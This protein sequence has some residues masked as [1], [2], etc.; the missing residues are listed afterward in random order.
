MNCINDTIRLETPNGDV[1]ADIN[2]EYIIDDEISKVNIKLIYNGVEYLASGEDYLCMDAFAQLQNELPN[3]V[4][5]KCCL[6]C[7]HGNFCPVGNLE[8]ELF[9]TKDVIIL[10]KSDLWLYTE[11]DKER[12]K[13]LRKYNDVCDD[14][15]FQSE[16]FYTYNDW[17]CFLNKKN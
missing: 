5:F 17:L 10:K 12:K 1:K 3:G 7:K 15:D 14:F 6:V 16:D 4:R 13:R 9:C 2:I 8:N 11:D